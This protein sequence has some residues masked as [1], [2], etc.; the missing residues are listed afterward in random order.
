[1]LS[2]SRTALL[3]AFL[4]VVAAL[5][6]WLH[7]TEQPTK[8]AFLNGKLL[9]MDA[10]N[11]VQQAVLIDNGRIIAV[12]S[13]EEISAQIDKSTLVTDLNGKTMMPGIVDAHGHFPGSGLTL[14]SADLNSP[15]IGQ[16]GNLTQLQQA[17]GSHLLTVKDGA[18]VFGI[19]YD[20]TLLAEKRHPTR[21]DLDQ[22]STEHPIFIMHVS[23]HMGV[24][25]SKALSLANIGADTPNPKGG[26]ISR[27][28]NGEPNGLLEESA[29]QSI[30]TM[31]T[32]F[33]FTDFFKMIRY[34]VNEY[35]SVGVTTAQSGG[36][37]SSIYTG[38]RWASKLGLLKSRLVVFPLSDSLGKEMVKRRAE[39]DAHNTNEFTVGP[40]KI[41]ADGSIQ[42]Y[43]GYLSQPYHTPYHGDAEFRGY[44]RL[45]AEELASEVMSY[46]QAG[47]QMAIHGNGD[48]AIDDIIR[49]FRAAQSQHLKI[50]PRLILIHAQMARDDQL[51]E[52]KTL[53]ISPS[54]FSAHTYYW[55]D[56]HS[57]RFMGPDRAANMSPARW[58]VDRKLPFSIHLDTPVV[59]M[60]PFLLAWS[61]VNRVSANGNVIGAG[62]RI[63][64][65][66]ALRAITIDAAWQVFEAD[67]RGSIEVGKWADLIVLSDDPLLN[68]AAIKDIQVLETVVAGRTVFDR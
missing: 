66:Q 53:G 32:D 26:M 34:A 49:A 60:Q 51:D 39:F 36:V 64:P 13:S 56:R 25:N 42:G 20:D 15:P 21:Y 1:M 46:H 31:A 27:D 40:I 41:I 62:Q 10:S 52:F 54:F 23:G 57:Q 2:A 44:P 11:S 6:A 12:G 45:S 38:L 28:A 19:G 3:G 24:A 47:L 14:L 48:A 4:F 33:S 7:L 55:G 29:T 9:T 61:A 30:Q 35:A 58:A 50:D 43:T 68:P 16:I 8:R 67:N 17:L 37:D 63:S 59:P 5:V 22:V 18:W 65:I